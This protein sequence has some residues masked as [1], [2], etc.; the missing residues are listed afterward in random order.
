M[1]APSDD[2]VLAAIAERM[3][4]R[5]HLGM[6]VGAAAPPPPCSP[7][8]V[9]VAEHEI[10]YKLPL[11]LCRIYT[12]VANGGVGPYL[13]LNGLTGDGKAIVGPL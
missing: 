7:E 1:N 6:E 10:G 8:L 5:R 9:T 12:E 4:R 13:G 11:L 3:T 2:E